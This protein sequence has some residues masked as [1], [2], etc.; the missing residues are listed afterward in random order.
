MGSIVG[1]PKTRKGLI[2]GD[3]SG[4]VEEVFIMRNQDVDL[5]VSYSREI[6]KLHRVLLPIVDQDP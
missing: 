3:N 4:Q 5:E 6:V 2:W 1:L